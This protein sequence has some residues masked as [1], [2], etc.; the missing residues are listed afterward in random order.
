M[1]AGAA[2]YFS[3]LCGLEVFKV[4][5]PVYNDGDTSTELN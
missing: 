5:Y 4:L 2:E 3:Y 1:F